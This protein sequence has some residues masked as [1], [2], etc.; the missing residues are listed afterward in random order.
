[1]PDA[2]FIL[3]AEVDQFRASV[4]SFARTRLAAG[5]LGRAQ[6]DEFPRA[7]Y[8]TVVDHGF[9]ALN[10]PAELGGQETDPVALGV[11]LEELAWADFNLAEMV[12]SNCLM[13]E[14]LRGHEQFGPV[15]SAIAAGRRSM[16]LGLTEPGAG[17]DAAA[18][19]TRVVADTGGWRLYGEKTSISAAPHADTAIVFAREPERG[20]SAFLVD[21]DDT[22]SRQRFDDPGNRPVGRGSLM[23]DGT[24][25]RRTNLLGEPGRG[26]QHAMR[27][28]DLSRPLLALMAV[29]T[30]QHAMD[31]TVEHV[32]TRETFGRPLAHNQ[33]VSFP[34]AE[35]D[36]RLEL[37]RVLGYRT[38]GLR[39]AG[40]PHT[41]EAAMLKW[42]GPAC[43]VRAIGEC[44]LLHGHTGWSNEMPLQQMLH[45]VSG[46][47]IG[48]GTAQIQKLV[49][50]RAMLGRDMVP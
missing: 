43:A 11:A 37:T 3:S 24:R 45:D 35:H 10:A 8:T 21:L 49:I 25:V 15:V 30:A 19:T 5:Y 36:T 41:R 14:L 18:I 42:W 33:G 26:F 16:A 38:L 34:L 12:F 1:M 9:A 32:R 17:S 40:R 4:R 29:G 13:V 39:M 6:S 28:F 22:V 31:L 7:A 48:D 27:V 50:A 20:V 44:I 46:M 23:F 47:Q 2:P